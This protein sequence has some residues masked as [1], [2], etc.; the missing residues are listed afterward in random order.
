M[1][2]TKNAGIIGKKKSGFFDSE[3]GTWQAIAKQLGIFKQPGLETQEVYV[4]HPFVY[5]TEAADDI[6]YRV[7]DI[8]DA[9]RLGILSY[10][11]A[12]VLFL[13]FFDDDTEYQNRER[14]ER[15]T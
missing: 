15:K 12:E 3:S 11:E 10:K 9:H 13:P 6:C 8:E 14:I 7:I 5:L 1:V 4:R 2:S